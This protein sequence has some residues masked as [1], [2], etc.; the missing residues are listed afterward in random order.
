[1]LWPNG[2]FVATLAGHPQIL[3]IDIA[4]KIVD[5]IGTGAYPLGVKSGLHWEELCG[6]LSP[7][8]RL[9]LHSDGLTEA[10][11]ATDKEFGD[12]YVEAIAGWQPAGTAQALVDEMVAE[13]RAF[14]TGKAVDDDMTLAVIRKV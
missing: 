7:G 9:L 13:W 3:K 1:L 6:T 11:N 4:G 14:T 2:E 12:E 8:E 10:R 5:R